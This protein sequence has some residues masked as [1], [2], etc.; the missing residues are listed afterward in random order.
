[1]IWNKA[2]YFDNLANMFM[3]SY[4]FMSHTGY[5]IIFLLFFY[6]EFIYKTKY[7]VTSCMALLWKMLTT[8][9]VQHRKSNAQGIIY[10][11]SPTGSIDKNSNY[12][13]TDNNAAK[14]IN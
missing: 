8:I 13:Q 9:F 10:F 5:Y 6:L 2:K 4:E 1:M 11:L 12:Y 3:A 7:L 14:L